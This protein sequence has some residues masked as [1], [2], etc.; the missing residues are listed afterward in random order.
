V[1]NLLPC[2]HT[3]VSVQH[4]T[5]ESEAKDGSLSF[6]K[7][8][9]DQRVREVNAAMAAL[10]ALNDGDDIGCKYDSRHGGAR[11]TQSRSF[12]GRLNLGSAVLA[13]HS[14]GAA[15]AIAACSRDAEWGFRACIA[16]DPWLYAFSHEEAARVGSSGSLPPLLVISNE[17]FQWESNLRKARALLAGAGKGSALATMRGAGHM[18]QSD[19]PVMFAWAMSL[20]RIR[21]D[22]DPRLSLRLNAALCHSFLSRAGVGLCRAA[23]PWLKSPGTA[24][25]EVS[26]ELL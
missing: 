13:G 18:S 3:Q 17:R 20:L 10:K 1:G 19:C 21:F 9:L 11:L 25:P 16:L 26:I 4:P 7:A 8:Q 23:A 2:C 15:T 14:F 6:R 12:K 24:P 22:V 5:K